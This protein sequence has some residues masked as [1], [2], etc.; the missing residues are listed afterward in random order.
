MEGVTPQE[1]SQRAEE[2]IRTAVYLGQFDLLQDLEGQLTY[3]ASEK[4]VRAWLQHLSQHSKS[5]VVKQ[6]A[7]LHLDGKQTLKPSV[8]TP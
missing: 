6:W 8:V 2:L 7:K 3:R 4:H 1:L 5:R